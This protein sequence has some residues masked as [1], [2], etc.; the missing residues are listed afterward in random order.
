VSDHPPVFNSNLV[1]DAS[2]EKSMPKPIHAVL[3]CCALLLAASLSVA[4]R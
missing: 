4:T 3:V 2:E 1:I